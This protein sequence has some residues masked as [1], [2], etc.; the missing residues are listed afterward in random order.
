MLNLNNLYKNGFDTFFIDEELKKKLWFIVNTEKWRKPTFDISKMYDETDGYY[1]KIPEWMDIDLSNYPVNN[2]EQEDFL[3]REWDKKRPKI[4]K[5][6]FNKIMKEKQY[7]G[8]L[9]MFYDFDIKSIQLWDGVGSEKYHWDGPGNDDIFF[10]IYL[11]DFKKWDPKYGGGISVGVR[12]L[13]DNRNW[14][15]DMDNIE[16]LA[17]VYP[18]DG[19]IVFGNN[20]SPRFVHKP[21]LLTKEANDLDLSRITFLITIKLNKKMIKK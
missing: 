8:N 20:M 3:Q 5:H 9:D 18:D 16:T 14:I 4:Y 11:S 7:N 12:E 21:I 1:K 6:Y 10:L 13:T 19:R 2:N 17:T 15:N